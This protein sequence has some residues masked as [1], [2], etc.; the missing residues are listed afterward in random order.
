MVIYSDHGLRQVHKCVWTTPAN[1]TP[2]PPF[3]LI[4]S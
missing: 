2:N 1:G 4:G 3:L